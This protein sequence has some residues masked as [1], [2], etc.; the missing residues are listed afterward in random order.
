MLNKK[1]VFSAKY[2]VMDQNNFIIKYPLGLSF[3][4]KLKDILVKIG[5]FGSKCYNNDH[6]R[7]VGIWQCQ[8]YQYATRTSLRS[9]KVIKTC[10]NLFINL[11][12]AWTFYN[13]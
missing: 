8:Y 5:D 2:F 12:V 4:S 13:Y 1:I 11:S 6:I 3:R 7:H 10:A 9:G